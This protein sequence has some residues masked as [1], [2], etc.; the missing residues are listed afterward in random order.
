MNTD[1]PAVPHLRED[2]ISDLRAY[3]KERPAFQ[4]H[5]LALRRRRR[6]SLGPLLTA[7]FENRDT[8]RYQIQEMLRAER[9]IHPGAVEAE[10]QAYNPLLPSQRELSATLF[11][12]VTDPAKV[13]E[14]LTR[15]AGLEHHLVLELADGRQ[16]RARPEAGHARS[17]TRDDVTS[18]VH[19]LRIPVPSDAEISQG[20]FLAVDHPEYAA[21][22]PLTGETL[23]ELAD[24]LAA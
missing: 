8:I 7:A 12:E 19:Y 21:R 6:V 10:L 18:A 3:E 9:S 16:L 20:A 14:W 13:R 23:A 4:R 5:V 24:D 22:V 2:E 1:T 17:L 11:V 15:L